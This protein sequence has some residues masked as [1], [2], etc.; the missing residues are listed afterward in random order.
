MTRVTGPTVALLAAM[1][2]A[3]VLAQQTTGIITGI[4]TDAQG[5]AIAGV[6]VTVTSTSTGLS[7]SSVTNTQ[8][9]YQVGPLPAGTYDL[10]TA[11]TGFAPVGRRSLSV[12]VGDRALVNVELPLA[13]LQTTVDVTAP[14]T[15]RQSTSSAVEAVVD[16][17]RLDRL[18][19]NGRQF[20]SLAT[21]VPGV[22]L[23]FHADP[24]K[25]TDVAPQISGASGREIGRAHV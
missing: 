5:K 9:L 10:I 6:T 3:P 17:T 21:T 8:G 14:A 19:L 24:T 12:G 2:V 4:V 20:A 22:G 15:P 23:G 7:R 13:P 1:T 11:A 16:V 18:P 25:S